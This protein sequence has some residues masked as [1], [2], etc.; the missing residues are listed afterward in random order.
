MFVRRNVDSKKKEWIN[1]HY[2]ETNYSTI[3]RE[4]EG[5]FEVYYRTK[6]IGKAENQAEIDEIIAYHKGA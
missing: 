1:E 5:T 4:E 3:F 2:E 6:L